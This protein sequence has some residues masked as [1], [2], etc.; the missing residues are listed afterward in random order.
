MKF[1]FILIVSILF[2]FVFAQNKKLEVHKGN[3]TQFNLGF[4]G[5]QKSEVWMNGEYWSE[6][7]G[8][9]Q[10]EFFVTLDVMMANKVAS[11]YEIVLAYL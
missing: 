6:R 10:K 11:S 9:F 5:D 1:K 2:H 4:N 7:T 3:K 8:Y